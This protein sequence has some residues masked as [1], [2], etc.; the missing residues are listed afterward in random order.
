[1][2]CVSGCALQSLSLFCCRVNG[3]LEHP[4]VNVSRQFVLGM[5]CGLAG[6]SRG[7]PSLIGELMLSP[8]AVGGL[9]G[10][11]PFLF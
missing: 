7:S 1:V 11:A 6:S 9:Q 2:V 3:N 10:T 4:L 5:H 8:F